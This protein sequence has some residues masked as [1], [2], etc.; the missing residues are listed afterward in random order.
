M[1]GT[2]NQV[3]SKDEKT[4]SRNPRAIEKP[5]IEGHALDLPMQTLVEAIPHFEP[6]RM[7]VGPEDTRWIG[8]SS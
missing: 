8:A 2:K 1:D 6:K 5:T 3:V 7:D 4:P